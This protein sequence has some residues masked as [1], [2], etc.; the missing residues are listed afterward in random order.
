MAGHRFPNLFIAGVPKAATTTWYQVLDRHPDVFMSEDKELRFL[1]QDLT[2]DNRVRSEEDYLAYFADAGDERRRGE[3]SPWYFY[4]EEAPRRIRECSEDPRVLVFL[5]DP[6]ER[7]YSLHGQMV[8]AGAENIEDFR[9]ALAAQADRKRGRR[10]P[11]LFEPREGL[12][13]R[14]IA[15]YAPHARRF[16]S[17]FDDD[18]LL[19]VR[20]ETFAERP[21]ELYRRICRFI[22]V[23]PDDDAEIPASNSHKVLRSQRVRDFLKDPPAPI[24]ALATRVPGDW[25]KAARDY[26]WELNLK[27]AERDPMPADVR[28]KLTEHCRRDVE[29]LEDLLGWDLADWKRRERPEPV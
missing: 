16:L 29:E 12:H 27:R 10:L 21:E 28:R 22:D 6:V 13:Y 9:E 3:A 18:E 4:S 26:L 23:D 20:F 1:D 17:T 7:L 8:N 11:D 2:F 24:Q 15:H 19:F 5:R 14:D 25:P